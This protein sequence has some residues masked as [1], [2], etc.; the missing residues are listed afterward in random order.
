MDNT[1]G[2]PLVL[3]PKRRGEVR[4]GDLHALGRYPGYPSFGAND[5]SR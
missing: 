2:T 5:V 1:F 4:N 3:R